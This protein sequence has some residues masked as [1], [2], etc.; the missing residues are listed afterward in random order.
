MRDIL[1]T[2]RWQQAIQAGRAYTLQ[3]ALAYAHLAPDR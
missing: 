3:E 2:Q 1:G